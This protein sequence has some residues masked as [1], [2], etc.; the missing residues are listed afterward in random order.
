[1]KARRAGT[2]VNHGLDGDWRLV[3]LVMTG[4]Y[5]S[6]KEDRVELYAMRREP[7]DFGGSV[8]S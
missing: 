1:V 6:S 7:S 3:S 4:A 2:G 8:M 5:L